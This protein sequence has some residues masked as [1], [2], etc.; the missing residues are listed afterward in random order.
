[1]GLF[2][3]KVFK[4]DKYYNISESLNILEQLRERGLIDKYTLEQAEDQKDKYRVISIEK[5]REKE[6]KIRK[7]NIE[8][9]SFLGRVQNNGAYR[10]ISV[11]P[12]NNYI[13]T[14]NRGTQ[15]IDR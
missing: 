11:N 3:K 4:E 5:S 7:D 14:D 13:Q 12:N 15:E 9:T 1:M 6:N 8:K 10:N 2:S